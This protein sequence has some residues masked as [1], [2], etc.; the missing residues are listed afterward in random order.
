MNGERVVS[1]QNRRARCYEVKLL[2]SLAKLLLKKKTDIQRHEHGDNA[3]LMER[4][5]KHLTRRGTS[6][7]HARAVL[8]NFKVVIFFVMLTFFFLV[9]PLCVVLFI[10]RLCSILFVCCFNLFFL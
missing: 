6:A 8:P 5:E 2:G 7:S 9:L 10:S 1:R 4:K 3:E